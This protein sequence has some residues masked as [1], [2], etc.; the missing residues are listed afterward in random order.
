MLAFALAVL[1]VGVAMAACQPSCLSSPSVC[2][3]AD[4][5]RRIVGFP[6]NA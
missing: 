6:G 3:Q 1:I 5:I 4:Y 2:R